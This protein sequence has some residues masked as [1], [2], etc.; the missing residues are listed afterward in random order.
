MYI[1][2]T[3]H[4]ERFYCDNHSEEAKKKMSLA[5]KGKKK[6]E[7]HKLN[8][9]ESLKGKKKSKKNIVKI[10]LKLSNPL[11]GKKLWANM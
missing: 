1:N 11:N 6:S 2:M 10:Y 4:N 5:S 9:S 3:I 8:I 7:N